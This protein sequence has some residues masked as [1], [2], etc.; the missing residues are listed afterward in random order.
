MLLT[1]KLAFITGGGGGLA[2]AIARAF[3]DEGA[4]VILADLDPQAAERS[5]QALRETG[6]T[7]HAFPIDVTDLAGCEALAVRIAGEIGQVS[8]LVNSAGVSG[9]APIDRDD[10][11]AIWHRQIDVNLS[12]T[13]HVSRAFF[14]HLCATKGTVINLASITSFIAYTSSYGYMA[15]KAGVVLLTQSLAKEFAPH[16]IR[17]NAVAPGVIN[18]EMTATRR[19]NTEAMADLF[20]RTPLKRTGEPSEVARPIVFLASEMASYITGVTLPIDGGMLAV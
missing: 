3:C 20:S 15:S 19:A 8:I 17:V 4:A 14:G 11:P 10:A 16:G 9:A 7:A 18:T 13:F 1:G 2:A 5:A 6:A 12:G